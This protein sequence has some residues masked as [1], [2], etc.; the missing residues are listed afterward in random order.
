MTS[1][2]DLV[3]RLVASAAK[4]LPAAELASLAA[5][6]KRL[7]ARRAYQGVSPIVGLA[8]GTGSGK[9]SLLNA[10]V[11]EYL[12][13]P[14]S[15]RPTTSEPLVVVPAESADRL[16][17][18]WGELDISDPVPSANTGDLTFVD[19]PD[20][21]SV[22]TEHRQRVSDLLIDL[23]VVV[24]V[25]D[26]EKYRDRVLHENFLRPLVGH[27]ARF[28]FALNQV[29]R[30]DPGDVSAV[31]DDLEFALRQDGF[32]EP[33]IVATAA[34]PPI[35]PPIGIEELLEAI[36]AKASQPDLAGE[37]IKTELIR[38]L[39]ILAPRLQ[40][41]DFKSRWEKALPDLVKAYEAGRGQEELDRF[42][43]GIKAKAPELALDLDQPIEGD[44]A[45]QLD[46]HIGRAIRSQLRPRAETRAIAT[47]LQLA[48]SSAP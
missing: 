25:T 14:G 31:S 10:L 8:G 46:L 9:S 16:E 6:A 42:V 27:Q 1:L 18:L 44:I 34:E 30:L 11:G 22:A 39:E 33:T 24:W 12:S 13:D 17:R 48:L 35:G 41:I 26:P 37:R 4:H 43:A 20:L 36:I 23:D 3:D 2:L 21:D 5:A 32:I 29:D 40:P 38:Q 19:L 7:R 15:S 47:E 28:V 45:R